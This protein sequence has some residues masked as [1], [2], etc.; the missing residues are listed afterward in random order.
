MVDPADIGGGS[1]L[2]AMG[3]S[4]RLA[5][6]LVAAATG[7]ADSDIDLRWRQKGLRGGMRIVARL[8]LIPVRLLVKTTT[9]PECQQHAGRWMR[10]RSLPHP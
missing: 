9:K 10:C 8:T 2:K 1:A 3:A 5:I 6:P 4:H 7:P